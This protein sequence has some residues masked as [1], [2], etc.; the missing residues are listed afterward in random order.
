M[1]SRPS[2]NSLKNH[3][4]ELIETK[5]AERCRISLS[6]SPKNPAPA[7]GDLPSPAPIV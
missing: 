6:H 5:E 2:N 7:D 1:S 4:S 3:S